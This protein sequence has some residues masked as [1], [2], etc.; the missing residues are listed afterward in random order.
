MALLFKDTTY[1]SETTQ[2]LREFLDKNPDVAKGQVEGR[3]LL[4]DKQIDRAQQQEAEAARVKQK[5][6]V[7]QPE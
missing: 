5:P 2:F 7:Y 3:A 1:V 4:W 6:Y